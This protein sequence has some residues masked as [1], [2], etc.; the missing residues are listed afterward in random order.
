MTLDLKK[1]GRSSR[2]P[3]GQYKLQT[4]FLSFTHF[5]PTILTNFLAFR[6]PTTLF[7]LGS[8]VS[9]PP[10]GSLNLNLP[11]GL[12]R[13]HSQQ[14]RAPPSTTNSAGDDPGA[15]TVERRFE[16]SAKDTRGTP[17]I[18][19]G[20]PVSALQRQLLRWNKYFP[21]FVAPFFWFL[22]CPC[23]RLLTARACCEAKFNGVMQILASLAHLLEDIMHGLPF[24]IA[25]L[26][27]SR[28]QKKH[29][30]VCC[31]S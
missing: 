10:F 2:N 18:F 3:T 11:P 5:T 8:H 6:D 19:L 15:C 27:G 21:S 16:G 24:L 20:A 23:K 31:L 17:A 7:Y 25:Q 26:P 12:P 22:A 4:H 29:A 28:I 1:G 30:M 13:P 9:S 14:P